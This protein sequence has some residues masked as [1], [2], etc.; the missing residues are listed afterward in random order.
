MLTA[1]RL[2]AGGH[3]IYAT[4]R[5]LQKQGALKLELEKRETKCQILRLDVTE[6][7]SINNVILSVSPSL[8]NV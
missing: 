2:A 7:K 6:D 1:A 5:N 8:N 3:T 4:M